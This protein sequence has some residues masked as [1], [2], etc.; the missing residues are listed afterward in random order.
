MSHE[1]VDLEIQLSSSWW[2]LPPTA[3]VWLDD[4]LLLD[5][6]IREPNVV[7][8]SG[9]LGE[10]SHSIKIDLWGKNYNSQTILKED[11]IVKDQLL[12]IDEI[13]IDDIPMGFLLHQNSKYITEDGRD[14][15]RCINLGWNGQWSFE[16]VVPVYIWLLEN[17]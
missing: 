5:A 3:K 2:D 9:N 13:L 17:F 15:K 4:Q 7:K 8:W 10:G 12:N 1:K 14:V 6:A 16:F 11:K